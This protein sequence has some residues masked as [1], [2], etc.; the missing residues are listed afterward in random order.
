MSVESPLTGLAILRNCQQIH[1]FAFTT[2]HLEPDP[3]NTSKLTSANA[4]AP[5]DDDDV[6]YRID[7]TFAL[8]PGLQLKTLEVDA[9]IE[10]D[11]VVYN[12]ISRLVEKGSGWRD[13]QVFIPNSKV[14][15]Y[16]VDPDEFFGYPEYRRTPQPDADST[17]GLEE[18][19]FLISEQELGKQML[20]V[21][22]RAPDAEIVKDIER[23]NAQEYDGRNIQQW[24]GN[25]T[26]DEI[27]K[28]AFMSLCDD[29]ESFEEGD[30]SSEEGN[31]EH[32]RFVL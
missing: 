12:T 29:D 24:A 30:G 10:S 31:F 16:K 27:R 17:L 19:A 25:M 14:L 21:V 3:P 11:I 15:A 23:Q 22:K 13:L 1:L 20:V 8:V 2:T 9:T 6:F 28:K 5:D 7:S 26:W 18:D 4:L 32:E